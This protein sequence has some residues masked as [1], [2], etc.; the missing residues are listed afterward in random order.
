MVYCTT[1][2]NGAHNPESLRIVFTEEQDMKEALTALGEAPYQH[3]TVTLRDCAELIAENC[4]GVIS[5]T[6]SRE[7]SGEIVLK[8]RCAGEERL[9]R[10]QG[11][12]LTLESGG[13]YGVRV[14]GSIEA[15]SFLSL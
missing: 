4:A 15:V 12:G 10:V 13:A 11:T 14:T 9:M 7:V 3:T 6:D 1:V 2:K 8:I 5:C